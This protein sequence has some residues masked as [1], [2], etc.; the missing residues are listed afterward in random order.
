ME[1]LKRYLRVF[2]VAG[3]A[4]AA[5][6]AF[7]SPVRALEIRVK[8]QATVKGDTIYLSDIASFHPERD[9]RVERLNRID[10]ASAPSPGNELSL[11][12]HFLNYKIGSVIGEEEGI[13]LTVPQFLIVKRTAQSL[14]DKELEEIFKRHVLS[15]SSLPAEKIVFQR[16]R[17][18]ETVDLPEGKLQW[19]VTEKSNPRYVGPVAITVNFLVDGKQIRKV[20]LSGMVSV[21]Q[22]VIKTARRIE[23]GSQ[24]TEGDLILVDEDNSRPLGNVMTSPDEIVGKRATRNIRAGQYIR[25]KM[26][27]DP[28]LV[29]K[30]KR[31][32]IRARKASINVTTLGKVM[33]DGRTG[34]QVRVVNIS[35][36]RQ[37]LGTVKGPGVVEVQF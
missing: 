3:I 4:L 30:G 12:R 24:I 26:I 9:A 19:E 29:K 23:A 18:P 8:E 1:S 36:G 16:I 37:I 5:S 20:L 31:V 15:H 21:N 33:E 13:Q 28:P 17:T 10:V 2:L 6:M 7:S 22:E 27:D 34:D 11:N 35:S 14:G 32:V 25:P